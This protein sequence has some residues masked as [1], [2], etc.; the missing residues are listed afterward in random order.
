VET[1]L[2]DDPAAF[3]EA[4]APLLLADEARHSLVLGL[5]ATMRDAP[6]R[7]PEFRLWLVE[8]RGEPVAAALQTPPHNLVLARPRTAAALHALVA[9]CGDELPGASGARPEIDAFAAAWTAKTGTTARVHMEQGLYR[10]ERLRPPGAVPGAL[11]DAT[12]E[13]RPLLLDWLQRFAVE[14][15]GHAVAEDEIARGVD[16]RLAAAEEGFALWDDGE[17]VCLAGFGGPTPNGIRIGPVYTPPALRGR[18]YA[19]ALV[20]ALS[21]R[22]LAGGRRFCFLFT[23]L[24]NPTANRLYRR[25]GYEHVCDGAV[26]R[27]EPRR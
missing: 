12:A 24:A 10:L 4:A 20:G 21:A 25:L 15:P 13:D 3:L 14:A 26:T 22:S 9:D 27:F 1:R 11:R 17:P 6:A 8:D 18:G 5:A 7:Y 19:S 2:V 23:D 16:Q